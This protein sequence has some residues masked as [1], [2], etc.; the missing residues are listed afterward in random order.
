VPD[1]EALSKY[2]LDLAKELNAE[3]PG[4]FPSGLRRFASKVTLVRFFFSFA[5]RVC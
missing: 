1:R 2:R 5:D 4:I 3:F